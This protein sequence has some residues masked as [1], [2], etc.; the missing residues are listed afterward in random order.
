VDLIDD[1]GR[2][3]GVQYD[4]LEFKGTGRVQKHLRLTSGWRL[5]VREKN[6]KIGKWPGD[7]FW[8]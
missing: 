3:W 1:T 5:F 4:G 6:I 8:P 2:K 7:K